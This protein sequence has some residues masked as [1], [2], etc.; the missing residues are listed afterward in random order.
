MHRLIFVALAIAVTS[1]AHANV[2]QRV[3]EG[4][5]TAEPAGLREIAIEREELTFD[6][7]PLADRGL[8]QVAAT[9]HLDNRSGT[10]VKA[11]LVFVTGVRSVDGFRVIFDGA[12]LG[13]DG[14]PMPLT[15]EQNA[16]LPAAWR[17]PETTP[18][19][20]GDGPVD[21][22]VEDST[23]LAFS[24]EIPPGR[25]RLAVSYLADPQMSRSENGG[26]L[27]WQLGYVLAPARDWGGFGGLE[28]SIQVPEGWRAAVSPDVP[29]T[30]DVFRARFATLPGETIGITLQAPTGLLH[31]VLQVV[32]PLLVVVVF[33]GGMIVLYKVGRSRGRRVDK[34]SPI[35]PTAL[36]GTLV[37][38]LAI[39]FVGG[40]A[41][42]RAEVA[43]PEGQSAM[44]GYGGMFGGLLTVLGTLIAIP[45]G[46][47][48]VKGGARASEA[49]ASP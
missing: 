19:L 11:P 6:L 32:L 22:A 18:G 38:A 27:L 40:L 16:A 42:T 8:P 36:A 17:P 41:V 21:Y 4:T 31:D 49:D 2:G 48:I 37:W 47:A 35:W 46:F 45:I 23:S 30:G 1:P 14:L 34:L 43:L 28:L 44:Y 12:Q 5:R 25:H 13:T 26:T 29:R 20:D 33:V 3:F 39:A 24:L 15:S 7:R 10:T 9:Y